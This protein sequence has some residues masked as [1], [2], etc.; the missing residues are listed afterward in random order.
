MPG[1]LK[2]LLRDYYLPQI[3]KLDPLGIDK[4]YGYFDSY[5]VILKHARSGRVWDLPIRL[6]H[7]NRIYH[8]HQNAMAEEP[9]TAWVEASSYSN[10]VLK[11]DLKKAMDFSLEFGNYYPDYSLKREHFIVD[12][13]IVWS[14]QQLQL[15]T[16]PGWNGLTTVRIK[17]SPPLGNYRGHIILPVHLPPK[18]RID[19]TLNDKPFPVSAVA[20]D[21]GVN[22]FMVLPF[23]QKGLGQTDIDAKL[24]ISNPI[25]KK[26][27]TIGTTKD[28]YVLYDGPS[29]AFRL[30]ILDVR[31]IAINL[32]YYKS[33]PNLSSSS[34]YF[35]TIHQSRNSVLLENKLSSPFLFPKNV[36]LLSGLRPWEF[37]NGKIS[38]HPN[39]NPH[40]VC[41]VYDGNAKELD[42]E[43]RQSP[44]W[45]KELV[46]IF[47]EKSS[48]HSKGKAIIRKESLESISYE[49]EMTADG[50]FF[51]SMHFH[52]NLRA[53]MD[54]DNI[55]KVYQAQAGMMAMKIPKGKHVLTIYYHH[56]WYDHLGKCISMASIVVLSVFCVIRFLR[57]K[58][59]E[60]SIDQNLSEISNS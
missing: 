37:F 6:M 54:Q 47:L 22:Y 50:F 24:I 60:V 15:K 16:R 11:D 21:K 14:N 28:P 35:H 1:K 5:D 12:S 46:P 57:R 40:N 25:S 42:G 44:G 17:F 45:E 32:L 26:S 9:N 4:N 34:S 10:L 58:T 13:S 20:K 30:A 39:Y 29:L 31:F 52:P 7:C 56:P 41:F 53:V 51:P 36:Y 59:G 49:I 2:K 18:A 48:R 23:A 38:H 43:V 8:K 19:I 33:P 3:G 27:V 55:I